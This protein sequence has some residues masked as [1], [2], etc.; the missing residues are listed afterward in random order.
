MP[1][2]NTRMARSLLRLFDFFIII[3]RMSFSLCTIILTHDKIREHTPFRCGLPE[4]IAVT[5]L[6][7]SLLGHYFISRSISRRYLQIADTADAASRKRR[8]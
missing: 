7:L 1:A 8:Q 5:F 2:R 6:R 3:S 4:D